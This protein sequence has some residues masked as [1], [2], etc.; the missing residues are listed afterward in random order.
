ME[1]ILNQNCKYAYD[2]HVNMQMHLIKL[3]LLVRTSL[4]KR[5]FSLCFFIQ[6]GIILYLF[7][8]FFW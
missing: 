7:Q 4:I 2:K 5:R 3:G 6:N 1:I 8:D